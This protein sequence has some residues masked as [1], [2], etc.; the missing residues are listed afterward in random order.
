[1]TTGTRILN[2]LNGS[3]QKIAGM[4]VDGFDPVNKTCYEM[5]GCLF[6]GCLSCHTDRQMKNP[7]NHFTMDYVYKETNKKSK[8]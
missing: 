8:N 6:H 1:M 3:E 4:F 5:L 7:F 2:A